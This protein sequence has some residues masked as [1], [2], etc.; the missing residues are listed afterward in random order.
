MTVQLSVIAVFAT[1]HH[2]VSNHEMH[3]STNY[4][5]YLL[6]LIFKSKVG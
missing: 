2:L 6:L 1:Y 5:I 3:N 4:E